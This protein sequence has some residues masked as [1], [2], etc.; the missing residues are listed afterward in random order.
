M[1]EQTIFRIEE[2][3]RS[4]VPDK[5]YP[6]DSLATAC[7]WEAIAA[8]EE[9]NFGAGCVITNRFG[10]V[11]A[12]GHNQVF[13]PKFRSD[14]HAEMVTMDAFEK[15]RDLESMRGYTLFASLEPCPMCTT[16]LISAGCQ[17]VR[18]V[19]DD[20]LGGMVRHIHRL[21]GVWPSL[22]APPRQDWGKAQCSPKLQQLA[23]DVF[24]SNVAELN[25]KLNRR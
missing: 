12:S 8:V 3:L 20:D 7:I 17:R 25:E 14:A 22:A 1:G 24:Q 10:A 19:A 11:I 18:Y 6:D 16:R 15:T 2:A 13:C 4:F 21:P 5:K 9:G 23:W